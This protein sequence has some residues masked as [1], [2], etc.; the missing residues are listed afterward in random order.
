L[1]VDI[2]RVIVEID[3]L[4]RPATPEPRSEIPVEASVRQL[5]RAYVNRRSPWGPPWWIYGVAFGALNL[6]R[7]AVILLTP[8]EIPQ[9]VRIASWGATALVVLGGVNLVAF[10]LRRQ[11]SSKEET[12]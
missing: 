12:P 2:D 11:P 10:V 1:T 3:R 9:S 5:F 8:A 7:Q 6:I 4:S